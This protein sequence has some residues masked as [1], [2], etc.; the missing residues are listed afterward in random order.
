MDS[1]TCEWDIVMF[2]EITVLSAEDGAIDVL[3]FMFERI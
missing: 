3:R 2:G 1:D